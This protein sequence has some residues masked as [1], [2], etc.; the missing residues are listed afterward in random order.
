MPRLP[1][2][3]CA[4]QCRYKSIL[5]AKSLPTSF[6]EPVTSDP[7]V[8]WEYPDYA[9]RVRGSCKEFEKKPPIWRKMRSDVRPMHWTGW[10]SSRNVCSQA[11]ALPWFCAASGTWRS[12][13]YI[14]YHQGLQ[15]SLL[16]QYYHHKLFAPEHRIRL[17]TDRLVKHD[18]VSGVSLSIL[19]IKT[20]CKGCFF[21]TDELSVLQPWLRCGRV[22]NLSP[23][24]HENEGRITIPLSL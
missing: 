8:R 7:E 5:L 23:F 4:P 12:G 17:L 9:Q 3:L 16:E 19:I 24:S 2:H 13:L 15:V 1:E 10:E 14:D 22:Y 11:G 18:F 20:L 21:R 6:H